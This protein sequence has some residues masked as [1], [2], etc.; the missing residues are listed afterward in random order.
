MKN[1]SEE[2]KHITMTIHTAN[3]SDIGPAPAPPNGCLPDAVPSW[4]QLT[5]EYGGGIV[6]QWV[7]NFPPNDHAD[8]S[9]QAQDRIVHGHLTVDY[10][11]RALV[12]AGWLDG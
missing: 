8:V 6:A 12:D 5:E 4:D 7:R 9:I 3:M 1:P 10:A 2:R 11:R